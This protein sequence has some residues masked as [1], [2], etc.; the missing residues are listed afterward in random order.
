LPWQ[1]GL[2]VAYVGPPQAIQPEQRRW[3]LFVLA[4]A[5]VLA[6]TSIV[7][8]QAGVFDRDDQPDV[9]FRA[10]GPDPEAST[11]SDR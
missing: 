8:W 10:V 2:G 9:V 6:A 7:L 11:R 3:P 4:G 5:G 1:R